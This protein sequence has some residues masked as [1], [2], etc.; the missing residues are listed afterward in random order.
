MP[1]N[2]HGVQRIPSYAENHIFYAAGTVTLLCVD[3]SFP[4]RILGILN[5][6][7]HRVIVVTINFETRS[8]YQIVITNMLIDS[9]SIIGR[10]RNLLNVRDVM[11]RNENKKNLLSNV[12][13]I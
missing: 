4:L 6:A 11:R 5:V 10:Y 3:L 9:R 2:E 12:R 13:E 1:R 8:I 7:Y